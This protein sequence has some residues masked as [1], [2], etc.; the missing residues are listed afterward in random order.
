MRKGVLCVLDLRRIRLVDYIIAGLALV[1]IVLGGW[2]GWS[3]WSAERGVRT[4]TSASRAVD[5]LTAAV[6][7]NPN[8]LAARLSLAQALTVAGRTNEAIKQYEAVLTV[9][10][11]SVGAL[12]GLGFIALRDGGFGTGEAYFRKVI[13]IQTAKGA[14]GEGPLETAYFYL[15]TALME[16]KEYEEAA[17]YFKEALRLKRDSSDS[18]YL[19]AVCLR[20]LG[21]EDA[22]RESLN[23]CLLFDPRHPEANYDYAQ[24]LLS[25]GDV[26]GAAEHFRVSADAAP[27]SSRPL[28]ALADLGTAQERIAAARRLRNTDRGKALVEARVAAALDPR[29]VAAYVELGNLYSDAGNEGKARDAYRTALGI[30]PDDAA[31][32]AGMERVSDEL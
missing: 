2:L 9:D 23:S 11:E 3:A 30:D 14:V 22:Y 13:D 24:L 1:V 27:Q 19:L 4:S 31:A 28:E 7:A 8:D 32:K 20:E 17:G 18:Y 21:H 16:Q 29:S 15:A 5:D 6:R 26:A 25:E 10:E 12:S